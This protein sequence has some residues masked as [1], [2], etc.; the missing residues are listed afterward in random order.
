MYNLCQEVAIRQ[1]KKCKEMIS[2]HLNNYDVEYNV[3]TQI[4]N[5]KI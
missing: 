1:S 4:I 5:I 3:V 2:I